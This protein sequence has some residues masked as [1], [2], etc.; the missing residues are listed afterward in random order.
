M[1]Y[2]ESLRVAAEIAA[3]WPEWKRG[4]LGTIT[5]Q[6]SWSEQTARLAKIADAAREN[7]NEMA[8]KAR[9]KLMEDKNVLGHA[10]VET[11]E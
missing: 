2:D 10:S 6:D 8:R 4:L 7:L 1:T 11:S 5:K 3:A 9:L